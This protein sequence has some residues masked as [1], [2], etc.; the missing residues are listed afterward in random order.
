MVPNI[1]IETGIK[2]ARMEFRKVY[3]DKAKS[4]R[5]VQCLKRYKRNIPV[6]TGEPA[7]PVHDEYSHGAD[8]FRYLALSVNQ[9]SNEDWKPIKYPQGGII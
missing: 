8:A 3:F 9:M 2:Q 7:S 1:P 5:L 6:S 4:D